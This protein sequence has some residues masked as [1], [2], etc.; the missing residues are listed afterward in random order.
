LQ[1][2]HTYALQHSRLHTF[3]ISTYSMSENH[4][5]VRGYPLVLNHSLYYMLRSG[6]L[7]QIHANMGCWELRQGKLFWRMITQF[8]LDS[9]CALRQRGSWEGTVENPP[10]LF[11]LFIPSH[12]KTLRVR[13]HSVGTHRF[14]RRVVLI[15]VLLIRKTFL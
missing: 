1:F 11:F 4:T 2:Y 12:A 14:Y 7:Q 13:I 8:Q 6:S 5:K 10:T 15:P 9:I 3:H